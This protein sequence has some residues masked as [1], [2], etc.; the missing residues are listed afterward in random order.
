MEESPNKHSKCLCMQAA[1]AT[2][3]PPEPQVILSSP[4]KPAKTDAEMAPV[5]RW[6]GWVSLRSA[7]SMAQHG[8]RPEAHDP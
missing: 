8:Q 4:Y 2:A 5:Y 1:C 6:V 7:H 3:P